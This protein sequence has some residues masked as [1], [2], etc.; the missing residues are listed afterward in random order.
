MQTSPTFIEK[1][2]CIGIKDSINAE[3]NT[4]KLKNTHMETITHK[5]EEIKKYQQYYKE[6][7]VDAKLVKINLE[8][9]ISDYMEENHNKINVLSADIN[10][11]LKG[12][13]EFYSEKFYTII[14]RMDIAHIIKMLDY[15][16]DKEN[17]VFKELMNAYFKLFNEKILSKEYGKTTKKLYE[18]MNDNWDTINLDN[19]LNFANVLSKLKYYKTDTTNFNLLFQTKYDNIINI[20]NLLNFLINSYILPKDKPRNELIHDINEEITEPPK[21]DE[22]K[23]NLRFLIENLKSN[24]FLLFEQYYKSIKSRYSDLNIES[25]NRDL[26]LTKHFMT[27]VAGLEE[28]NVNRYVNDMLINIRN[29][30]FDLQ[31]SHYN[32][33]IYRK[34]KI[35]AESEKYKSEDISKYNRE[36]TNFQIFKYNYSN[37]EN[38]LMSSHTIG[39][40]SE[41]L[42]YNT[43]N[44]NLLIYLDIYRS[45][46]KTRYPDREIEYDL[47]DS[48]IIVKMKFDK[49]YYIHMSLIQYIILDIIMNNECITVQEI[50]LTTGISLSRLN[51]TFNSLLKIKIIKRTTG[52]DIKFSLNKDFEFNKNKLSISGLVKKE[53]SE[54]VAQREFMHDRNMIVLC[55]LVYYAKKNTYFSRDTIMDELTYKVPFKLNDEYINKAI[56]K[57][58]EDDYI[59][60]KEIPNMNGTIDIMYQYC[61]E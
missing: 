39:D 14:T 45:F 30:L 51:E 43:V 8:K 40:K 12:I 32:N 29:Y 16:N 33:E 36:L 46:F 61:D 42:N 19:L 58:L 4:L 37:Q 59:K 38:I 7:L 23:Y 60:V 49:I 47:I 5:I 57:A 55:N 1:Y 15:S 25:I 22:F 50:F 18:L 9:Q 34:I 6:K 20:T 21:N 3:L 31:E 52:P 41:T 28:T 13:S 48:T 26:V 10:Y 2:L 35:K 24:G 44:K 53:G 54:K 17:I 27:I 56:S 11:F